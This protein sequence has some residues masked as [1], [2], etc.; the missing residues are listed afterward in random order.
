MPENDPIGGKKEI[1]A[2]IGPK[3]RNQHR[4]GKEDFDLESAGAQFVPIAGAD[5]TGHVDKG[6][7]WR[8]TGN[9]KVIVAWLTGRR[10]K[11]KV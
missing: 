1:L 6:G 5:F 8:L 7:T 11:L 4:A 2:E 3:M 10:R 9:E